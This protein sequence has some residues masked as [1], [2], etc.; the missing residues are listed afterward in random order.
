MKATLYS[1]TVPVLLNGLGTGRHLLDK[2][3]AFA[4]EREFDPALM[5]SLRL[6]PDQFDL[7]R[8]IQIVSDNAK[9]LAARLAGM[10]PPKMEDTETTFE[11]L[12]TRI[13]RTIEF[14]ESVSPEAIDGQEDRRIP[15][16]YASGKILT[17]YNQAVEYQLPNFMF[18]LVTAYS[19]L[20]SAGVKLGKMDFLTK[21][22]LEDE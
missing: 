20:R 16:P 14:I 2:A 13:D 1:M 4:K 7:K 15:F 22:T 10:E 21:V 11:E 6:A 18:H 12:R 19:I 9:G 8:Q 3:E 17:G 5:L